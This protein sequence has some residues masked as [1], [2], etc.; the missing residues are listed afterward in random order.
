MSS[1]KFGYT[2]HKGS[3]AGAHIRLPAGQRQELQTPVEERSG[4]PRLLSPAAADCRQGEPQR[5]HA[6][7]LPLQIQVNTDAET[8]DVSS[9]G[10]RPAGAAAGDGMMQ[11]G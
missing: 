7:G 2:F 8:P 6:A 3:G 9:Q 5:L 4:E 1:S 11:P 10:R